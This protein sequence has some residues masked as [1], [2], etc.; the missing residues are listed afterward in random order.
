MMTELLQTKDGT[1]F[2][3]QDLKKVFLSEYIKDNKKQVQIL[4]SKN[5]ALFFEKTG[6]TILDIISIN[7]IP[8]KF[9]LFISNKIDDTF[10]L[11]K[12]KLKDN[13]MLLENSN[14]EFYISYHSSKYSLKFKIE[15]IN[16]KPILILKTEMLK[17]D[18]IDTKLAKR[19]FNFFNKTK[20]TIQD[21]YRFNNIKEI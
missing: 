12:N 18:F 8:D 3:P 10:I 14:E 7:K 6:F 16:N 15:I 4:N 5:E 1:L 13:L 9:H 19:F 17:F 20:I 11:S 2:A 21:I